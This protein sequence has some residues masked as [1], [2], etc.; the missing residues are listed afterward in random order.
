MENENNLGIYTDNESAI[1]D[2]VQTNLLKMTDVVIENANP[3][4]HSYKSDLRVVNEVY[5]NITKNVNDAAAARL[6]HQD[7]S[8]KEAILLT[9][10]ETLKTLSVNKSNADTT[11]LTIKAEIIDVDVVKG[12]IEINPEKLELDEFIDE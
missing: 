8:N 7:N 1:L 9:V 6:K 5:A 12:E 10:A 2:K 4:S 11:D 3:N